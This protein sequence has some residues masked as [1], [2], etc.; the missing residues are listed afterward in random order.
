MGYR[1]PRHAPQ[2]EEGCPRRVNCLPSACA[3]PGVRAWLGCCA[4]ACICCSTSHLVRAILAHSGVA[5]AGKWFVGVGFCVGLWIGS[6]MRRSGPV[7]AQDRVRRGGCTR[8][9]V[10]ALC[11]AGALRF[12]PSGRPWRVRRASGA[13]VDSRA[14]GCVLDGLLRLRTPAWLVPSRLPAD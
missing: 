7:N 12:C 1:P 13:L 10:G 2:A 6:R 9:S 11:A 14:L 4:A 8:C 5:R 3:T